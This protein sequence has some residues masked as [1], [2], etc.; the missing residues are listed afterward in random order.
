[1]RSVRGYC[2][3]QQLYF[4][5]ELGSTSR[6]N[7]DGRYENRKNNLISMRTI[8]GTFAGERRKR[9]RHLAAESGVS[10]DSMIRVTS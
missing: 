4:S 6:E 5:N 3:G 10:N 7:R 1:L 9:L 8:N 2:C